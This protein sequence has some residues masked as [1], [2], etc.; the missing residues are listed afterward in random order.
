M[1]KLIKAFRGVPDG[2]IYPH[3]FQAGDECPAELEAGAIASG[4]LEDVP[5][6][7]AAPKPPKGKGA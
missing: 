2:E 6:P 5:A 1:A 3:E 7:A 4:A